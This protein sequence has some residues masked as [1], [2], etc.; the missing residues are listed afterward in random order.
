MSTNETETSPSQ[1][2]VVSTLEAMD[3]DGDPTLGD[4]AAYR[5]GTGAGD[6]FVIDPNTGTVRLAATAKLD[7]DEAAQYK[8][9]EHWP[10]YTF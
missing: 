6:T 8:A 3:P 5:L 7:R 10:P 9:S 4:I 2:T 1:G